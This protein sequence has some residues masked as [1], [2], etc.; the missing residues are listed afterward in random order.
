MTARADDATRSGPSRTD[1]ELVSL[2]AA[3][4]IARCLPGAELVLGRDPSCDVRLDDATVSRRHT[5]LAW[6]DGAW[7]VQDLGSGNGTL[8]AGA[9]VQ[10]AVLSDGAT[11][12]VGPFQWVV[13]LR[14]PPARWRAA[15]GWLVWRLS[16]LE[17]R[18]GAVDRL[19]WKRQTVLGRSATADV[20]VGGDQVSALHAKLQYGAAGLGVTDLGSANGTRVNGAPVRGARVQDG[21]RLEIADLPFRLRRTWVPVPAVMGAA[22][23][24]AALLLVLA[25][26]PT[27]GRRTLERDR[28]WTR[29]MYLEQAQRSL[30]E[31][32]DAWQRPQPAR[33]LA[34]ARFD[35]A[36]R[37]LAAVDYLPM[38]APAGS[39][40]AAALQR[41]E[42]EFGGPL[43]GRDL[44]AILQELEDAPQPPP[45]AETAAPS[46]PPPYSLDAELSLIMAEFGI[47]VATQP[48]P[49]DLVA[50]IERFVDYWSNEKRGFTRR[51]WRR[52]QQHLPMIEDTLRR[53][54]LPPVFSYLPFIES[55][56]EVDILSEAGARGLWQF[57]PA[58]ARQYG[59]RVDA[60]VDERIDPVKSTEAACQ[61]IEFLLNAFGANSFMSAIAAYNKGEHGILRCLGRAA[62][63]RSRW[64]FWDI[65][66]RGD[67]LKQETIE[68]VPKFLAAAVVLRR[69]D[70]FVLEEGGV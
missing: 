27:A 24:F 67:C 14:R 30:T 4:A 18:A 56:F 55:R 41:A 40:I 34:R 35:I 57:M 52:G 29:E 5:R 47:D 38:H 53:Y 66:T 64:N 58:T 19:L 2:G 48:M 23:V 61:Y 62:D 7:W 69:P 13:R 26:L 60:A 36:L 9:R 63:W 46:A 32:V 39:D 22:G 43:Q 42:L 25:L 12:Q 6:Q 68:Y 50:A 49:P 51:A 17:P 28:W 59:L 70:V 54:R 16:A 10:Q 44:Y 37:S 15:D 45:V 11:L 21:D 33:E 20:V 65:A 31:A 8:L 1:L 3:P